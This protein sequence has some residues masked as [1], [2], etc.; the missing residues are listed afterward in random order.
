MMLS[1]GMKNITPS[2]ITI[3]INFRS[4]LLAAPQLGGARQPPENPQLQEPPLVVVV[5]TLLFSTTTICDST[6]FSSNTKMSRMSMH[7]C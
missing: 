2:R 3:R 1:H 6:S 4:C 5:V 7:Y